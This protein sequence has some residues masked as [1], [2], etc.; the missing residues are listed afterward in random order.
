MC[1]MSTWFVEIRV[2]D[3]QSLHLEDLC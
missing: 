2:G 1:W 3:C